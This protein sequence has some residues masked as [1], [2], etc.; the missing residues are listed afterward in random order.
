M[1]DEN[2]EPIERKSKSTVKSQC[3]V[4]YKG[5]KFSDKLIAIDEARHKELVDIKECR[6]QLGEKFLH[7]EQISSIPHIFKSG[8]FYHRECYANFSRARSEF[9]KREPLLEISQNHGV[10]RAHRS[11]EV[12]SMGR[13]PDYCWFCKEK[14]PK[15]VKSRKKDILEPVKVAKLNVKETLV[16]AATKRND[17]TLL[18]CIDAGT[19][20]Q[21]KGFKKHSSC[22]IEY[23]SVL[24][25]KNGTATKEQ[26]DSTMDKIRKVVEATVIEER[27]CMSLDEILDLKGEKVKNNDTRKVLK[28]WLNRNFENIE[29]LTVEH[30]DCQV[31]VSKDSWRDVTTGMQSLN[32]SITLNDTSVVKEAAGILQDLILEYME[33]ADN[34]PWP[35]TVE[36]LQKR[37]ESMPK[38]LTEFLR[39]LLSTKDIHHVTSETI[40]RHISSFAQDLVHSIS[41]GSFLQLKHTCVGLG[42]HSMTGMKIPI[43]ILSRL[44]NS[45]TYDVALEIETAQAELSQQFDSNS[46]SLPIQPKDTSSTVPTVFWFDNFDSFIDN[47]TGAGSIHNTPGVVFQEETSSTTKRPD[48]SIKKTKKRSLSDLEEAPASKISKINPKKNPPLIKNNGSEERKENHTLLSLW[49]AARYR[50]RKDQR[51]SR[52]AGFVIESSKQSKNK[53][54]LTYLPPIEKPITDY[55]C[56]FEI[57]NR[58][59]RL[60]TE[61]NM[62]YVHIIMDCGAAMKMCHVLWNNPEK[63]SN[64]IIHL[65]DFHFMQAFF[66][67][68]G[69]F[70]SCS[71]FEDIVY[72]LGLCQPGSMNAMI[73]GKHYNQA[74]MIHEMFAEAIVRLFLEIYLPEAPNILL[75]LDME[76][77][78]EASKNHE[79]EKYLQQYEELTTKGLK[80]DYG[81]TAQF[82]LRYVQFVD[83]QQ[84]LHQSIQQNNFDERLTS[85]KIMLALFAFFNKIHYLRYGTM[86]VHQ[87]EN[88]EAKYPGARE[89]MMSLGISVRRN[90]YGIEQATDLAGEQTFMRN[91]KTVG[92]IKSFQTRRCTVLKWV[93]NR[94]Q[95]TRFVEGL[96]EMAGI[97]KTTQNLRK[98]LRPTEIVKSNKIVESLMTTM[99]DQFTQPFDASF[100]K[101]KLY[102]I[103]SGKPID[104]IYFI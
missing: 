17:E 66:D 83:H 51:Y 102:N 75:D 11:H 91:A 59:E 21:Q 93:K 9:K 79:I 43:V 18:R 16:K 32:S 71:G 60:S 40:N 26:K 37:L 53:T 12:D 56:L 96:K 99:R 36:S 82:W 48:V 6:I 4:H 58:A 39:L 30:N 100:D 72:Q 77:T 19:D 46:Q 101:D 86:Y 41:K 55:G 90:E 5:I 2:Y 74:W 61:A 69:R 95:Q 68:I 45:I 35:P 3:L 33:T 84:I 10:Q 50:C 103:V 22:Y 14:K 70:A 76:S 57:L 94:A 23:T 31:I 78:E 89:E 28:R 85:W 20:L 54:V 62:K 88:M 7:P 34:L 104:V 44:G 42:L 73:K 1:N 67:V 64:V 92:G 29:F 52:F 63:Y 98:C 49:K 80:G 38:M 8:L 13:F 47:N 65:G 97:E 15:R 87:L 27:R 81:R 25:E 24:Y